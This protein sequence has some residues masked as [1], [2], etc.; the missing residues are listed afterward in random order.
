VRRALLLCALAALLVGCGAAVEVHERDLVVAT[1]AP[2]AEP[3]A[4]R[5]A[6]RPAGLAIAVVTHGQAASGFWAIVKNGIDA[7]ARAADVTAVYRSPDIYSVTRMRQ[8]IDQAVATRPDGL[9]VSIPSPALGGAI[10]RAVRAGIPVISINSGSDV[11][12][13]LGVLAHVG[14]PEGRAGEA[15]GRRLAAMG[16]RHALCIN[17]EVGNAGTDAR[18]RAFARAIR[19]AGGT[20]RLVAVDV[21]DPRVGRR[22][23]RAALAD[24][25]VDGLLTLSSDG[26]QAALDAL[27][28]R[29]P[30]NRIAF[31]TFDLSPEI[32]HALKAGRIA[33][34]I[35]QQAYLQ[36]YV[37]ILLLSQ[38][39]RYGLL[40][41]RGR[42]IA[43]GPHFV[44]RGT[45]DQALRL[46][47]L[48]I[49]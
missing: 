31:G 22:Q 30:A 39:A 37:P 12:R 19:G 2:D 27:R 40:P 49:R 25:G 16:V 8:L 35:D 6:P 7:A 38:F 33:F 47:Q 10:R 32:L 5:P 1:P 3:S 14:Q 36:G 28:T 20:S 21:R 9:V 45:A 11:F 46:S 43:T 17:H 41:A 48:G 18:C 34:A 4:Q 44:T 29:D 26:A 23:L 42:V 15:A 13:R 24:R